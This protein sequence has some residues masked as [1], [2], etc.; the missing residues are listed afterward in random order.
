MT[1]SP[2]KALSARHGWIL[3]SLLTGSSAAAQ[4]LG[5][6]LPSREQIAPAIPDSQ[7]PTPKVTIEDRT[8]ATPCDLAPSAERIDLRGAAFVAADGVALP[9]DIRVLLAAIR[10][11]PGAQPIANLCTLRDRAAEA[12]REAGYIAAVTIPPQEI[13]AGTARFEVILAHFHDVR[14]IGR[15]GRYARRL[16]QRLAEIKAVRPVNQHLLERML[17][18]IDDIPGL[19]LTLTLRPAESGMGAIIGDLAVDYDPVSLVATLDNLGSQAI[20]PVIASSRI[21]ANGLTGLADRS[22]IGGSTTLGSDEQR[23]FQLGHYFGNGRGF[24]AG[25]RFSRASTRPSLTGFDLRSRSTIAGIDVTR[26]LLRSPG[27]DLSLAVGLEIIDQKVAIRVVETN[28]SIETRDRLRVAYARLSGSAQHGRHLLAGQVEIRQGLPIL[29]ASPAGG[30]GTSRSGSDSTAA[31]IRG[32]IEDVVAWGPAFTLAAT[33]DGQWASGP[34]LGFEQYA[35]GNYTIGR[36]YDPGSASRDRAIG[37]R[38]EPRL[39]IWPSERLKPQLFAFVDHVRT[40]DRGAATATVDGDGHFTSFGGGFRL[41]GPS[42]FAVEAL[43]AHRPGNRAVATG[44]SA[45]SD[46]LLA[47]VALRF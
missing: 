10:P 20:G 4:Q 32:T 29:R 15:P 37:L 23:L 39:D 47:S 42:A 2:P 25:A 14:L 30:A 8:A 17:L 43:Y 16:T 9:S 33:I 34:V 5:T 36:G 44:T 46:R 28:I 45:A 3:A 27:G 41:I 11:V 35:V 1:R 12:L 18:A 13:E 6:G 7:A 26:N 24:S 21:E 31:V 38:L 19:S 22:Y 40:W